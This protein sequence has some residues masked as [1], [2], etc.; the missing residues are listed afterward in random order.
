MRNS[1]FAGA[2]MYGGTL[3]V[4]NV[5]SGSERHELDGQSCPWIAAL[6][7]DCRLLVTVNEES[8]QLHVWEVVTGKKRRTWELKK[9]VS[10]SSILFLPDGRNLVVG[11]LRGEV[12]FFDLA[13]GNEL[14]RGRGHD[15]DVNSLALSV[16]AKRLFSGSA[17]T[18]A[19]VWDLP[20]V[21]TPPRTGLVP[22]AG[23][24]IRTLWACL[25]SADAAE[26]DQAI[27]ALIDSPQASVSF[28][29]E[30]LRPAVSPEAE[31]TDKLIAEL[32]SDRFA[33]RE[34]A[35]RELENL[36]EL[37]RQAIS[38]TL[39]N[40]S[41]LEVRE[42]LKPLL[43]KIERQELSATGLR[44]IRATEVLEHIGTPEARELL[45]NLA[46]GAPEARST[47]DAKAAVERLANRIVAKP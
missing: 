35:S 28:L 10:V 33:V 6:S 26:A 29:K 17:D 38:E 2:P 5:A 8:N 9:L 36:G 30:H 12:D 20:S 7:P 13:S 21:F 40:K 22:L 1:D 47:H 3:R 19:L 45:K 42:R 4:W 18:T 41:T 39:A 34:N 25:A 44:Q 32:D 43:A 14:G 16:D 27:W 37:A 15:A 46:A 24:G 31:L 23:G 11:G